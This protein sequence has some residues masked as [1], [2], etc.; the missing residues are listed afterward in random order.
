MAL[1]AVWRLV[2][3]L[4]PTGSN[5]LH[6]NLS[7][8]RWEWHFT[9]PDIFD[10]C[11]KSWLARALFFN[12]VFPIVLTSMILVLVVF[13]S[14]PLIPIFGLLLSPLSPRVLSAS[15]LLALSTLVLCPGLCLF[16]RWEP[17][18]FS[19]FLPLL[20]LPSQPDNK[21]GKSGQRAINLEDEKCKIQTS[22][23]EPT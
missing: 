2:Y 14:R 15:R 7:S 17:T 1:W 16:R 5:L 20:F 13:V 12:W 18:S 9:A 3:S 22:F 4:L 6:C 19:S 10:Y 11:V 23:I 21:S 8:P